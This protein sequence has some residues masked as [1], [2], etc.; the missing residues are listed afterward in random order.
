MQLIVQP[1]DGWAPVLSVIQRARESIDIMIFRLDRPDIERA[2]AAAVRRKVAV[3]ALIAHT[4][5]EG[6]RGLRKLELRLLAAGVTVSRTADDLV[7]YH[8]KYLIADRRV[9][10]LLGFNFTRIDGESRSFGLEIRTR[11]VVQEVCRLFDA[12]VL[13][14]PWTAANEDVVVSPVNARERLTAFIKKAKKQLLVYD[15]RLSDPRMIRLLKERIAAGVDVRVIGRIAKA[16]ATIPTMKLTNRLHVRAM[17]ADGRRAFI[18][19][20]SLRRLELDRRREVGLL[21]REMAI[22][23]QVQSVF[24]AD[25]ALTIQKTEPKRLPE[26]VAAVTP[27]AEDAA[28][29]AAT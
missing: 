29:A 3:R 24:E 22:V 14:Q 12:D 25:W 5:S 21:V 4:N 7:R 9:L 19:S 13:R 23:K 16:G 17:V 2:L 27:S 8:P 10:L 28:V 1:D 15:P 11:P 20:Q 18:G 6:E 26:A